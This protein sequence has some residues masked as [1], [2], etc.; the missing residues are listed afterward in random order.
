MDISDRLDRQTKKDWKRAIT[1]WL[2]LHWHLFF[3]GQLGH[4]DVIG[5]CLVILLFDLPSF[6]EIW[7]DGCA[8]LSCQAEN[9]PT[10]V[11]ALSKKMVQAT[12]EIYKNTWLRRW[13]G[14]LPGLLP[15]N[16]CKMPEKKNTGNFR[17]P[18]SD[19]A[20][21]W[22]IFQIFFRLY[23]SYYMKYPMISNEKPPITTT[24]GW[25]LRGTISDVFCMVC[26][27][28]LFMDFMPHHTTLRSSKYVEKPWTKTSMDWFKGKST[29]NH[30]FSQEIWG[31]PVNFPLN[32]SIENM[33]FGTFSHVYLSLESRSLRSSELRPTPMK[34]GWVAHD[35]GIHCWS[36]TGSV[37]PKFYSSE[38]I[39]NTAF[40][41]W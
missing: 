39:R 21:T 14:L 16:G 27:C 25:R 1:S 13:Q 33:D 36:S 17:H 31:F 19:T 7:G 22:H 41:R 20:S 8:S 12:L 23:Q 18:E 4:W 35:A 34:A 32:Q 3:G 24:N 9:Y 15:V 5:S 11:A 6:L 40:A 26:F 28:L 38:M 30:R 37:S 10:E 29:G 2:Q